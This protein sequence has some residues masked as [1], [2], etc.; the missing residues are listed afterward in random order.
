[1]GWLKLAWVGD[2]GGADCD[3][4]K[5]GGGGMPEK[6]HYQTSFCG[7]NDT[8]LF[9]FPNICLLVVFENYF[10]E[11]KLNRLLISSAMFFGN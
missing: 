7:E 2:L 6:T 3:G 9:F 8:K 4:L 11:H 1:M 10:P 5:R